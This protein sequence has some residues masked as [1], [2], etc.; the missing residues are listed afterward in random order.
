M[1]EKKRAISVRTEQQEVIMEEE[2]SNW[3]DL[4]LEEHI[5]YVFLKSGCSLSFL[6][7]LSFHLITHIL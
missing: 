3:T 6:T 2:T 4:M 1:E 5:N 7:Q